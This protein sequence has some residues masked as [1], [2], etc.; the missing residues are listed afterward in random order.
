MPKV[1]CYIFAMSCVYLFFGFI[2]TKKHSSYSIA[3][4]RK[5]QEINGYKGPVLGPKES[6]E[7]LREFSQKLPAGGGVI[8]LQMGSNKGASQAG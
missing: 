4:A 2:L 5:A 6:S 8:G 3:L 7:S 1:S